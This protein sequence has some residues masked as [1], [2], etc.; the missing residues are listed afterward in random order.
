MDFKKQQFIHY[1][2][3]I[4]SRSKKHNAKKRRSRNK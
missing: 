4:L 2:N 3:Y 1:V